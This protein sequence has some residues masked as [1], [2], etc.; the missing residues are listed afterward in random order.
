MNVLKFVSVVFVLVVVVIASIVF[1]FSLNLDKVKN[2]SI[3]N[4]DLTNY[5]D[6]VYV[7]SFDGYRWSNT[8][9]VTIKD[10]K[11]VNIKTK[12]GMMFRV[13]DVEDELINNVIKN[14]SL[15]V[16][17]VSG[18]TVSSKAILKAIENALNNNK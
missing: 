7:G 4:I 10:H 15:D 13:T 3:G 8:V 18:A 6:G 5:D 12:K 2:I 16:D 1:Y 11:I 14:Q 9:E 17:V